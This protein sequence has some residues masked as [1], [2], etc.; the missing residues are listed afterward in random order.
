MPNCLRSF[1]F[2]LIHMDFTVAQAGTGS[3]GSVDFA[4]RS[5]TFGSTLS[6]R[7]TFQSGNLCGCCLAGQCDVALEHLET[8]GHRLVQ[9][10]A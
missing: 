4:G 3:D 10:C 1:L 9:F 2:A 8:H 7:V 6:S 5:G